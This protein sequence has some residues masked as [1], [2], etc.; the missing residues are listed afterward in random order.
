MAGAAPYSSLPERLP[1]RPLD[2]LPP[3]QTTAKCGNPIAALFSEAGI[4][5]DSCCH[6]VLI[7]TELLLRIYFDERSWQEHTRKGENAARAGHL[8]PGLGF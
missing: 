7:R 2:L 5:R 3:P 4:A 1:D 6:C 8:A